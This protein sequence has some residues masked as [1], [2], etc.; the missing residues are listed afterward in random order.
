MQAGIAAPAVVVLW[1]CGAT[2]CA[3]TAHGPLASAN[4]AALAAARETRGIEMNPEELA[5]QLEREAEA[6][7]PPYGAESIDTARSLGAEATALLLSR[8]GADD[9][10]AFLALEALRKA[11]PD[12]Y[13][14]LPARV[15]ARIYAE[16]LADNLYFN[17]W[18]VPGYQ[19][20]ETSAALISIGEAG[21]AALRPLLDDM[22]E[23][24]LSG[25]QDATTSAM[26]ANRICDY[27]WVLINE[28]LGR[29]YVYTQEPAKRDRQIAELRAVLNSRKG[30]ET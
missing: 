2:V 23:A 28:I 30:G 12:V 24:P 29:P 4:V 26:Y 16:A 20:T 19:L 1:A 14:A 6:G 3:D 15:R 11:D 17:A 18:G 21:I 25:S 22:R 27:A 9:R 7:V 8:I 13:R 5:R 10:T